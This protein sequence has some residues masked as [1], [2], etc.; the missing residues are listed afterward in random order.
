M[1]RMLVKAFLMSTF[2]L[3]F[4]SFSSPRQIEV[5][6]VYNKDADSC[7]NSEWMHVIVKL[8]NT[9]DENVSLSNVDLKYLYTDDDAEK[10]VVGNSPIYW[11]A[12]YYAGG[13]YSTHDRSAVSINNDAAT[14]A[15]ENS[16]IGI[17]FTDGE[18]LPCETRYIQFG[19][20]KTDW[21]LF[22]EIDDP[23][24][25][26]SYEGS[27]DKVA[28]A[29]RAYTPS[30]MSDFKVAM[31]F[32]AR[33]AYCFSAS[34]SLDTLQVREI[35]GV[36]ADLNKVKERLLDQNDVWDAAEASFIQYSTIIPEFKHDMKIKPAKEAG[37][38]FEIAVLET[39]PWKGAGA[40]GGYSSITLGANPTKDDLVNGGTKKD[41]FYN[42]PGLVSYTDRDETYHSTLRPWLH[43]L[44]TDDEKNKFGRKRFK[45]YNYKWVFRHEFGHSLGLPHPSV[46]VTDP[47]TGVV[48]TKTGTWEKADEDTCQGVMFQGYGRGYNADPMLAWDVSRLE[49]RGYEM[50]YPNIA[51]LIVMENYND[52]KYESYITNSWKDAYFRS[53]ET[54][55]SVN[56]T[57]GPS[58]EG[59]Y[60]SVGFDSVCV[61]LCV[62]NGA[63]GNVNGSVQFAQIN[64]PKAMFVDKWGF[65]GERGLLYFN[66]WGTVKMLDKNGV[67]SN[68]AGT[69]ELGYLNGDA[70][71]ARFS[72]DANP[73]CA[74]KDG[75]IYVCENTQSRI[76]RITP[77]GTV[78]LV[79]GSEDGE[80]G[81]VNGF[82]SDVR[83]AACASLA[84]DS[85][86][87]VIYIA[88]YFNHTVRKLN[89]ETGEV[90]SFAGVPGVAGTTDGNVS[91]AQFSNPTGV[92]YDLARDLLYVNDNSV[93][94]KQIRVIDLTTNTVS[95]L[96]GGTPGFEDGM[97]TA[98]KFGEIS[99]FDIDEFGNLWVADGVN[100][101][102]RMVTPDGNV[103][104]VAGSGEMLPENNT[105]SK[106]IDNLKTVAGSKALFRGP[107]D[108]ACDFHGGVYVSDMDDHR[109]RKL[110]TKIP[111]TVNAPAVGRILKEDKAHY[112]SLQ[113]SSFEEDNYTFTVY[114]GGV[115]NSNYKITIYDSKEIP[116]GSQFIGSGS[117]YSFSTYLSEGDYLIKVEGEGTGWTE[118]ACFI[119]V[120]NSKPQNFN[121]ETTVAGYIS[122]RMDNDW[123]RFNLASSSNVSISTSSVSGNM[124]GNVYITV[125]D[126]PFSNE[127]PVRK[128]AE[129][130]SSVNTALATGDYWV[131]VRPAVYKSKGGLNPY[132][133]GSY[134]ITLIK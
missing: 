43:L 83:F 46:R 14:E 107:V 132:P 61:D 129:G 73:F 60:Y 55:W 63:A 96:A 68:V 54:D 37:D 119:G 131:R 69:G 25:S 33:G 102:V 29:T 84:F 59:R 106:Y 117:S 41:V 30:Y 36:D 45:G 105:D 4:M 121:N 34:D 12:S 64:R 5:L 99:D 118:G 87:D 6:S 91:V 21:S 86:R 27:A 98:A 47:V 17:S 50:A 39:H 1:K 126:N 101:A 35:E 71:A 108:V 58:P 75:N 51:K 18:M 109:I 20:R 7:T 79:A 24:Y 3:I 112:Y 120:E 77:A 70:S 48:S 53:Y 38:N 44:S 90:T 52:S 31:T 9:S 28:R 10:V 81:Y 56:D 11:Y 15:G 124:N 114:S 115:L 123:Y 130:E 89:V 111:L 65:T 127:L 22:N 74:D 16:N 116:L 32:D 93:D 62:G 57:S 133:N 125:Y 67:V 78:E 134:S 40:S 95:T 94:V 97:G 92:A 19:V 103:T 42:T 113:V 76:R 8:V 88:E 85:T 82:G 100:Y 122:D 49:D 104:T 72:H 23:S 110:S 80:R 26:S 13:G 66:S 128:V 2:T